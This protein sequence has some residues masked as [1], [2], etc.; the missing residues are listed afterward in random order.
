ML[1]IETSLELG[2]QINWIQSVYVLPE[3]R[4][5][6]CFRALYEHIVKEARN[7]PIVKAVR[8][9]VETENFTA[10]T[11]YSK[12]GMDC[13]KNYDFVERDIVLGH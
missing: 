4:G 13:L 10:Q 5:K 1:T 6:G 12:L 11:V 8:L 7:D 2:G 9:Y 3:A